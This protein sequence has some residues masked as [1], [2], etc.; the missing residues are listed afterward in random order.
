MFYK[1]MYW[2][3]GLSFLLAHPADFKGFRNSGNDVVPVPRPAYYFGVSSPLY[4]PSPSQHSVPVVPR[5]RKIAAS[6]VSSATPLTTINGWREIR[7]ERKW[8][9]G[10]GFNMRNW[11]WESQRRCLYGEKKIVGKIYS[12][13]SD[14]DLLRTVR[15][16][17]LPHDFTTRRGNV[18]SKPGE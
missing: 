7:Q 12:N 6:Y 8:E 9:K 2:L 18:T 14:W 4:S 17:E 13:Q 3:I 15:G 1:C 5:Q 11:N 10:C 16:L